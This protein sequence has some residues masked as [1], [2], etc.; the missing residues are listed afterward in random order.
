MSPA[1]STTTLR[2]LTSRLMGGPRAAIWRA[3]MAQRASAL[4]AFSAASC[5]PG[6][7]PCT[8]RGYSTVFGESLKM[9]NPANH[10]SEVTIYA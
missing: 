4:S 5:R 3:L 9:Q 7:L 8:A 10:G 2:T 6:K 1:H